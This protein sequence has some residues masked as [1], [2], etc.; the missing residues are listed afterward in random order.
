MERDTIAHKPYKSGLTKHPE[1]YDDLYRASQ[2]GKKISK[3]SLSESEYFRAKTVI[4]QNILKSTRTNP[5]PTINPM[6]I[7]VYKFIRL[8][9]PEYKI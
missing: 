2:L 7:Q 8:V 5:S 9:M 3:L 1:K 4:G 6:A